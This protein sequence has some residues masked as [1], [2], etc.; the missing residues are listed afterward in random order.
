MGVLINTGQMYSILKD[1]TVK[2]ADHQKE[3]GG[4]KF[5][6]GIIFCH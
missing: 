6:L 2:L 3:V 1:F 4:Q 5:T